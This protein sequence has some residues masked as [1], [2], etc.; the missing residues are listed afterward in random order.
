M[1]RMSWPVRWHAATHRADG[2]R[3]T[4]N[5]TID[6]LGDVLTPLATALASRRRIYEWYGVEIVGVT[7]L[8]QTIRRVIEPRPEGGIDLVEV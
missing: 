8:G 4:I 7:P 5:R 6:G 3:I 2:R 1:P